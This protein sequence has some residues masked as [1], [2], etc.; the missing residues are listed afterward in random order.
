M[1]VIDTSVWIHVGRNH[2][3]D[4]FVSLWTHIDDS[5][6]SGLIRSPDEVL[7]ELQQGNDTL[8]VQL[9]PK[10]GLF[11]PL[12]ANLQAS[13]TEVLARCPTLTDP[14]SDRNR[15]DP[16]VVALANQNQGIVVTNEK[17]RRG[18]TGRLKI[19]D[20]CELLGLRHLDWF[21]FLREIGWRL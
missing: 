16:F 2:P 11:S 6:A 7:R 21:G 4:I 20:A 17:S 14:E 8:A 10:N 15:A 18:A 13:V 5:I 12:D 19:P 9:A 3:T 1:Y